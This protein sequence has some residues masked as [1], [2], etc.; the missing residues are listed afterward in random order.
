MGIAGGIENLQWLFTATFVV[1]LVVV[2]AYGAAVKQLSRHIL[3]PSVYVFCIINLL[4]FFLFIHN[5]LYIEIVARIFF[6][7]LSVFNLLIVSVFWSFMADLFNHEQAGRLFG[8]IAAGGSAGAIAG[9]LITTTLAVSIGTAYLLLIAAAFLTIAVVCISRI[10]RWTKQEEEQGYHVAKHVTKTNTVTHGSDSAIG[11]SVI[12]GF[13]Q[14]IKSRY[15]LGIALYIWLFTTLSTFLYFEQAYIV[16]NAF[17]DSAQRT[18]VFARIDLAVNTLTVLLQL[19]LTSRIVE[20][21]GMSITLAIVPAFL[22]AGFGALSVAPILSVIMLV[23]IIRRAGNYAIAKPGREMLFT[24]LSREQK[25]KAKNVIDTLVYRG[26][27]ALS[28]WIFAGLSGYGLSL[29]AI[30]LLAIPIAILW[31]LTGLWLGKKQST[32]FTGTVEKVSLF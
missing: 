20:R 16:K 28:G 13:K 24:V 1:M 5:G 30:A 18:A 25:Y 3:L 27:D 17:D 26:G 8:F 29:A 21:F 2:P 9:P 22:I 10:I 31:L 14:V 6:V 11:G 15:L 19:L 32:Y 7:W 4:I 12:A 23:Q